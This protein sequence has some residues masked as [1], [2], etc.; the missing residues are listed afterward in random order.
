MHETFLGDRPDLDD[1]FSPDDDAAK[2]Q[3]GRSV[4]VLVLAADKS[5]D[6]VVGDRQAWH[7]EGNALPYWLK[8][9]HHHAGPDA[10]VVI[11]ITRCDYGYGKGKRGN[12]PVDAEIEVM[13]RE[14]GRAHLPVQGGRAEKG[15]P[16]MQGAGSAPF[17]LVHDG[18]GTAGTGKCARPTTEM[19]RVFETAPE[20]FKRYGVNVVAVV[21]GLSATPDGEP[22]AIEKLQAAITLAVEGIRTSLEK[23]VSPKIKTLIEVV[24]RPDTGLRGLPMAS[25]THF[26]G[27]CRESD[28]DSKFQEPGK[29]SRLQQ[30]CLR[31]IDGLGVVFYFG[32]TE[33]E[34]EMLADKGSHYLDRMPH[35]SSVLGKYTLRE[36]KKSQCMAESIG[37]P[38]PEKVADCSAIRTPDARRRRSQ[39]AF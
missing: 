23:R 32:R 21:D 11:A 24:E 36:D 37:R 35:C 20:A 30:S 38:I 39:F 17:E 31:I 8:M 3:L 12:R 29:L 14:V 22:Q 6:S 2:P 16:S 9:L 33:R 25:F 26:Q 15:A 19:I 34:E 27:W 18:G 7:D 5:P 10:P 1:D 4:Y 28:L 13:V